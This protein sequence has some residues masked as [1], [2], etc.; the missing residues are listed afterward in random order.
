[1]ADGQFIINRRDTLVETPEPPR[2]VPSPFERSPAPTTCTPDDPFGRGETS[3]M[4]RP[5]SPWSKTEAEMKA[6]QDKSAREL[7][8][9]FHGPVLKALEWTPLGRTAALLSGVTKAII[10]L[11]KEGATNLAIDQISKL[12]IKVAAEEVARRLKLPQGTSGLLGNAFKDAIKLGGS[13]TPP[14]SKSEGNDRDGPRFIRPDRDTEK[15]I[16]Q[17]VDRQEH[18]DLTDPGTMIA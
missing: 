16:Q 1:M 9:V 10:K 15:R 13:G 3:A 6:I 4:F 2:V 8:M 18:R 7:A 17:G 14:K 12:A 5:A 11:N